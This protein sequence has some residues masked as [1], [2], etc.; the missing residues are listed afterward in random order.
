[1]IKHYDEKAWANLPDIENTSV[2]VSI[3][4]LK[5]LHERTAILFK[6]LDESQWKRELLHP[7]R[8]PTTVE[9]LCLKYVWHGNHH[10]AH[11][12]LAMKKS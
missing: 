6:S 10:F 1:M 8:G 11:I 5:T 4:M 12:E 2:E 3:L 9:E 7:M